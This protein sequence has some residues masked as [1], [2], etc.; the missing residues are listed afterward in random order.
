MNRRPQVSW[1]GLSRRGRRRLGQEGEQFTVE[2]GGV[3]HGE[4]VRPAF[5]LDVP[6]GRQRGVQAAPLPIDGQDPVGRAVDDER[7]DVETFDV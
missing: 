2:F 7:G 3:G 5:D 4:N 1:L 6:G